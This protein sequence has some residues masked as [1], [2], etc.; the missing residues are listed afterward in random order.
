MPATTIHVPPAL[1]AAVDAQAKERGLSRNRLILQALEKLVEQGCWEPSFLAKL[2][3]AVNSE[4]AGELDAMM[5]D[6]VRRRT[7]KAAPTL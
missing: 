1:L 3:E 6:V 2:G 4:E 5:G 7:R